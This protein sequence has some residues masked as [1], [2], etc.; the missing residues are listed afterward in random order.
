MD[1]VR[2]KDITTLTKDLR[3]AGADRVRVDADEIWNSS[4]TKR[5][6]KRFEKG[7]Q[8]L[9][10]DI[11]KSETGNFILEKKLVE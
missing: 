10:F 2:F 8:F 4:I 1:K 3:N 7:K 5:L 6:E 11:S 9:G